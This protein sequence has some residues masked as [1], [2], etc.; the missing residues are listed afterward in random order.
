MIHLPKSQPAPACLAVEK[1][2]AN[3]TYNCGDVLARLR[4]DFQNKC[5]L[6]EQKAPTTINIEHFI[7]HRGDLDLKF[8][9]LNLFYAC[10]H[11]NNTKLAKYGNIL[12]CTLAEDG[13][14]TGIRYWMN[15]YPKEKVEVTALADNAVVTE[16]VKLL[17][18]I[19][20]G[21]T[22]LKLIESANIRNQILQELRAFQELLL[23]FYHDL[24]TGQ[25]Q[26]DL[27]SKI[28]KELSPRSSFTAFKRCI[29][30]DNPELMADFHEYLL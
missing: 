20:N 23:A 13:V 25:E 1:A 9:W 7:P 14:E 4:E 28:A 19:Y 8:A 27:R 22:T 26:E 6:C 18:D 2:K 30:R 12:N 21:T 24:A 29:I 17:D 10:G 3:G 16:T 11:C 5:Y 15:P